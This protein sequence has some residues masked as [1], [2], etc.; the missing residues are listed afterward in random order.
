MIP[1]IFFIFLFSLLLVFLLV[2]VG[3]YYTD[4]DR[5]GR[6]RVAPEPE[7][8]DEEIG[9]GITMLFFFLVLFPML[10]AGSAWIV[11]YG[12]VYMGITW[13]PIL[14]LGLFL[15]LMVA[16]VS[17]RRPRRRSKLTPEEEEVPY[18]AGLFGVSFFLLLVL[19]VALFVMGVL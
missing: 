16:A 14:L 2:P 13:V 19:A 17:P 10:L 6:K 9:M 18:T 12:P 8:G 11:P 3:G 15:A 5:H 4:R 1:E 7:E